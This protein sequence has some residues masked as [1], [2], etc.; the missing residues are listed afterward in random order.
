MKNILVPTDFSPNAENALD[1]A[2][3]VAGKYHAKIILFHVWQIIY[4]TVD[5]P[6]PGEVISAQM[7]DAELNA[8][9]KMKPL[10]HKAHSAGIVDCDPV[11][12]QGDLVKLIPE[13]IKE[14]HIDMVI[15]GTKGASGFKEILIGSHTAKVIRVAECP[16]IAIPEKTRFKG[17]SHIIYATDYNSSDFDALKKVVDLAKHFQAKITLLHVSDEHYPLSGAK[18]IMELF[19]EKVQARVKYDLM[20]YKVIRTGNAEEELDEYVMKKHADLF[21]MSTMHRDI[22]DRLFGRSMT[23]KVAYHTRMPLMVFHHK[24]HKVVF[25]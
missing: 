14:Y 22:F 17:I 16:V 11:N 15:M 19:A 6:V 8:I 5:I 12:R 24:E 20:D 9:A 7:H 23:E 21:V 25:I 1:Y 13:M 18:Q 10:C 4:P 3:A 2:I